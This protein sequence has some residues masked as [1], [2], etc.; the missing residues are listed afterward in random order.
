[1]LPHR[2]LSWIAV[3]WLSQHAVPSAILPSGGILIPAMHSSWRDNLAASPAVATGIVSNNNSTDMCPR[4][5]S[6]PTILIDMGDE[7]RYSEHHARAMAKALAQLLQD[8]HVQVLWNVRKGNFTGDGYLEPLLPLFGGGR[9]HV[10]QDGSTTTPATTPKPGPVVAFVHHGGI[11]G[12]RQ[13]ISGR[14]PQ[15][16]LPQCSAA[17]SFAYLAEWVGI[18]I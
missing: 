5:A 16:I 3:L 9:I 6:T 2:A 18:G 10:W 8:I 1:M 13:A 14:V 17:Y 4:L 12:H 11:E 15:V 7:W